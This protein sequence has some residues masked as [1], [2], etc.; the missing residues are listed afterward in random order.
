MAL[1]AQGIPVT[2]GGVDEGYPL[3][4]TLTGRDG[5]RVDIE[6]NEFP[7]GDPRGRAPSDKHTRE[8][9]T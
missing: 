8:I 4:I 9:A 3:A 7:N 2:L 5:R 1:V 6:L